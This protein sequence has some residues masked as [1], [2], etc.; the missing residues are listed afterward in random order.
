MNI[1]MIEAAARRMA[2]H[3]R[4][5]PPLHAPPPDQAV[6]RGTAAVAVAAYLPTE[7]GTGAFDHPIAGTHDGGRFSA[8]A[9]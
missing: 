1:A 9:R 3:V 7:A 2:G 4:R 8:G 5:T 6:G